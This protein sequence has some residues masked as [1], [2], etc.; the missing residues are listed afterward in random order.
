MSRTQLELL[1]FLDGIVSELF[2]ELESSEKR[3]LSELF[4]RLFWNWISE[5]L[6][7][8]IKKEKQVRLSQLIFQPFLIKLA[9][10]W[11]F[12]SSSD[13][14]VFLVV[15]WALTRFDLFEIFLRL[16]VSIAINWN[17]FVYPHCRVTYRHPFLLPK[18][19]SIII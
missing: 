7:P 1:N 6:K 3:N 18:R 16:L 19:D 12:I 17:P 8:K 15:H 10:I 11:V 2:C 4:C 9:S 13:F 14:W 5:K